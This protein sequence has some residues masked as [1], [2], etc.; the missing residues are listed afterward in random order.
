[1]QEAKRIVH[2][3][4]VGWGFRSLTLTL[5]QTL[6]LTLNI[7]LMLSLTLNPKHSPNVITN[8]KP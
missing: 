8:P 5:N 2:L 1:M 3:N 7:A 4:S 6:I